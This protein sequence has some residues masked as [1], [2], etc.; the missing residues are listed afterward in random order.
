M[1]FTLYASPTLRNYGVECRFGL[2][3]NL[4]LSTGLDYFSSSIEQE[5]PGEETETLSIE[6]NSYW[7]YQNVSYWEYTDSAFTGLGWVYTDSLY[8]SSLDSSYTTQLDSSMV[9]TATAQTATFTIRKLSVPIL[10]GYRRGVG[11]FEFGAQLGGSI[12]FLTKLDLNN[13]NGDI[14]FVEKKG[15][16]FSFRA[17]SYLDYRLSSKLSVGIQPSVR[18]SILPDVLIYEQERRSRSFALRVHL[19]LRI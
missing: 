12:D 6:D 9:T 10:I 15:V 17:S 4:F 16:G 7:T 3:K 14:Q 18:Y 2:S 19:R 13:N 1:D 8:T 11:R 5:I